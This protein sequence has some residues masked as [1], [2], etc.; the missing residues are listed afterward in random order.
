MNTW[1]PVQE[2]EFDKANSKTQDGITV[3]VSLSPYD[4]PEAVRGFREVNSPWFV[5]EFR[6]ISSEPTRVQELDQHLALTLGKNSGRLF[7]IR[8]NVETLKANQ[9]KLA[10]KMKETAAGALD[11]FPNILE[12]RQHRPLTSKLANGLKDV[13]EKNRVTLF[14]EPNLVSAGCAVSC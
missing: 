13:I 2:Q 8:M 12:Q 5:I 3:Q 11:K 4:I 1:L 9:V 6:Y 14:S 10:L 7:E